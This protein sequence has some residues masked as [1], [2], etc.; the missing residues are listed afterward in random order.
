MSTAHTLSMIWTRRNIIIRILQCTDT[1]QNACAPPAR[2]PPTKRH[3]TECA[4]RIPLAGA[5]TSSRAILVASPLCAASRRPP[6]RASQFAHILHIAVQMRRTVQYTTVQSN[7]FALTAAAR[8]LEVCSA[9]CATGAA[10][11]SRCQLRCNAFAAAAF[12]SVDTE[13]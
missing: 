3:R 9:S 2:S 12:C 6:A 11:P 8:I 10:L 4:S 5:L 1:V 13:R 7:S